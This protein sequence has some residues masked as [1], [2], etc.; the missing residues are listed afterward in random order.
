MPACSLRGEIPAHWRIGNSHK[1]WLAG[2]YT[3]AIGDQVIRCARRQ[4]LD[5]QA[6]IGRT[7]RGQQAAIADEEIGNVVGAPKA[8][9]DRGAWIVAHARPA[10]KMGVAWLLDDLARASGVENLLRFGY[11]RSRDLAIV[12]VQAKGH[13][14]Y[15]QAETIFLFSQFHAVIFPGQDFTEHTERR[16]VVV[17]HHDAPQ[18]PAPGAHGHHH[19][20]A[21]GNGQRS[22]GLD[23]EAANKVILRIGFVELLGER[24][25]RR[26]FIHAHQF[27][28]APQY[29]IADLDHQVLTKGAAGIGQPVLKARTRR[30]QEQARRLNGVAT[31]QHN[32]RAQLLLFA[33]RVK[34]GHAS[35]PAI[36]THI[37]ARDHAIGAKLGSM[38]QCV[39]HMADQCALL[40]PDL[41][42]LDTEAT[43]DTVLAVAVRTLQDGDRAASHYRNAKFRAAA[44][45]HVSD[46]SQWMRPIGIAVRIAPGIV[47]WP[48][49]GD[50]F[51]KQLVVGLEILVGDGP[52]SAHTVLRKH[53]E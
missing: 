48:G 46:A 19:L 8:I 41:A 18:A 22:Y 33:L 28:E 49:N 47:G 39:R 5:S 34:V 25:G 9:G 51:F 4:G 15:A 27:L 11:A 35:H 12:L 38:A 16:P 36:F 32:F 3:L 17:V 23:G 26:R 1:G 53:T 20:L 37:D 45:Q 31:D 40:G 13:F 21:K 10:D 14:R 42:A 44:H 29:D 43:I 24:V 30:V 50:L 7:L 6:G 52:V 2:E